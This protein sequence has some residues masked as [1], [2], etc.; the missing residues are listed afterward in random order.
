MRWKTKHY[1]LLH[2]P[3]IPVLY[4][5]GSHRRLGILETFQ[6]A[7][8][9]RCLGG[10]NPVDNVAI[11][12]LLLALFVWWQGDGPLPDENFAERLRGQAL[13]EF[14]V[15]HEALFNLLG[16]GK[17]FYQMPE[18][19]DKKKDVEFLVQEVPV[20]GR[21]SHFWHVTETRNG[22]C[23]SCCAKGLV[24]L[25]AF[26]TSGGRG[27]SPGINRTPP[28]Y[29]IPVGPNLAA[30]LRLSWLRV[31]GRPAGIPWWAREEVP[32]L[33]D[34]GD[35]PLL[36]GLTWL[37]RRV[38]LDD[39]EEQEASCTCCGQRDRLVLRCVFASRGS[40]YPE[41]SL[42]SQGLSI[43]I[44]KAL[45]Q[46]VS[47]KDKTEKKN[48]DGKED[49]R[50]YYTLKLEK[51]L[52]DEDVEMLLR[53]STDPRWREGVLWLSRA[54]WEWTDPHV[55][56]KD[57]APLR[58]TNVIQDVGAAAST[59][60]TVIHAF[61]EDPQWKEWISHLNETERAGTRL[62]VV[63]FSTD[64]D[65]YLETSELVL[66]LPDRSE[67]LSNLLEERLKV[68]SRVG[69]I[70]L[71]VTRSGTK[72]R[73]R[74]VKR[75]LESGLMKLAQP[76]VEARIQAIGAGLPGDDE[77]AWKAAIS[78][79]ASMSS[80][81]AGA[82]CPGATATALERRWTI[83]R[84]VLSMATRDKTSGGPRG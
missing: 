31:R 63:A 18:R 61:L 7:G 68:P 66:P 82:L 54:W 34:G 4:A 17:R 38:W 80:T 77:S 15:R 71:G 42:G 14:L 2:E 76:G 41:C 39:P 49:E 48:K 8:R 24:R 28:Y 79:Y 69:E 1:N 46:K 21:F 20:S 29:I 6:D 19:E 35:V 32:S 36:V 10:S 37:P 22:L 16:D 72:L 51:R 83:A 74:T 33:P 58:P 44:P 47:L 9:I 65:R 78:E 52:T 30:T 23:L 59:W 13:K 45:M 5:D 53:L 11:L 26:M 73:K 3:W 27:Y 25:P 62:A 75:S 56:V 12:R 57:S 84:G 70:V 60:M 64:Q 50:V 40:L 81:L 55:I 43:E 67:A